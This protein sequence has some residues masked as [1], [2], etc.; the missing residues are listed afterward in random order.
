MAPEPDRAT[1]DLP[2]RSR[3][4][5]GIGGALISM[6]ELGTRVFLD[7]NYY[8]PDCGGT[9]CLANPTAQWML[10]TDWAPRGLCRS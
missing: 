1:K 6:V 3:H 7:G 2:A 10:A 8:Q 9:A 4:E 5:L